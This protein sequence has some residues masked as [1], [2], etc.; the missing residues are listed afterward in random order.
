MDIHYESLD[1]TFR[2]TT[3]R[4]VRFGISEACCTLL[5]RMHESVTS[6]DIG[7]GNGELLSSAKCLRMTEDE[8]KGN[9]QPCCEQQHL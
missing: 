5:L 3:Q 8:S 9:L 4:D 7:K 2:T 1:G 6:G